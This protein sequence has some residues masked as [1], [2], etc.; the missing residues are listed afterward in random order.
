MFIKVK[1][2]PPVLK[3]TPNEGIRR[4]L[5]VGSVC[6]CRQDTLLQRA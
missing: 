5:C 2:L 3:N 1:V 4:L 6:S